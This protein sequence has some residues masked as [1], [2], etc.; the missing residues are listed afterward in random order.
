MWNLVSLAWG[1]VSACAVWLFLRW[2]DRRKEKHKDKRDA[3]RRAEEQLEQADAATVALRTAIALTCPSLAELVARVAANLSTSPVEVGAF[4]SKVQGV[5]VLRSQYFATGTEAV[6]KQV[7]HWSMLAHEME[8]ET[9]R[10]WEKSPFDIESDD[11]MLTYM[12]DRARL[13]RKQA[14]VARAAAVAE[15]A[16]EL[17]KDGTEHEKGSGVSPDAL[18]KAGRHCAS[19]VVDKLRIQVELIK[20]DERGQEIMEDKRRAEGLE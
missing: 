16:L 20:L 3:M 14:V 9:P 8:T 10:L 15:A 5:D 7:A 1:I 4:M 18:L 19:V 13:V 11:G 2:L 12:R 17:F 6:L